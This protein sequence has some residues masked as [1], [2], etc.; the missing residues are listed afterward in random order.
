MAITQTETAGENLLFY[1]KSGT[2]KRHLAVSI[3]QGLIDYGGTA[4]YM[5]AS[6]I[7]QR[8]KETYGR[9]AELKEREVYESFATPDLLI[10]DEEGRQFGTDAEKLMLL[11]RLTAGMRPSNQRL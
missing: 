9:Q 8:I 1:G 6:K 4:L 5:R 7:A 10:I 3:A 11:K 2:G